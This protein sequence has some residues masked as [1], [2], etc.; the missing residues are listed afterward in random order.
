MPE[1]S[2]APA[3]RADVTRVAPRRAF[4][5]R[6]TIDV[7][8]RSHQGL[9]RQNNE[10]QF[11]VAKLTRAMETM[12]AS[13]P[14]DDVPDR[15]AETNYVMV[16]ADGMGGHAAGE[17]A[18][19]LAIRAIVSR[20]LDVPDWFFRLDEQGTLV[21]E[22][23]AREL[24]QQIGTELIERG[25]RDASLR[26]MGTTLTAVRSYGRDLLIV[27]VGDSRAYLYRGRQLIRLTKDHTYVQMLVDS[28]QLQP[29]EAARSKTRHILTN[30]LGGSKERVEVDVDLL[31]LEN[32]S[33]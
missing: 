24:L 12:H 13:V 26:G 18:S 5:S 17:V 2:T 6:I 7:A 8:A 33:G 1:R 28:G 10:D 15:E 16:V 32:G 29:D 11:F 25:R 27:H 22:H 21:V 3:A 30:V 9:V 14:P 20:A 23:R 4:S 19:R 31:C